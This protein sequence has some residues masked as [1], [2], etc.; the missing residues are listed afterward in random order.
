MS[1]E[2]A[3]GRARLD[4]R[5]DIY[6]L[7]AVL[8][9]MLAG[10]PPF[11]GPTAQA[12]LARGS[13]SAAPSVRQLRPA[14]PEAVDAGG[15]EGAGRR[16]RRT[17]SPS[18][19]E[20][21]RALR[22]ERAD[23]DRQRR[24]RAAGRALRRRHRAA[25]PGRRPLGRAAR[26]RLPARA[27]RAVRLAPAP[28]RRRAG[29][30]GGDASASPCCPFDNLGAADDEY[31]ADGITDEIRGKLAALPGLQVT[32][33][34]APP[35]TRRPTRTWRRSRASWAWTICWWARS[36]GRKATAGAAGCG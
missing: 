35:S 5:T 30:A 34:R 17:G 24:P 32:A 2:Q 22:A 15:A 14:V 27:R 23:A 26:P 19:G 20:L 11:T 10:E 9:E 21:A 25:P 8:Y 7:G 18:A 12:M 29:G 3:G 36:A 31:F 1:P 28:R 6:S 16:C 4:A 13:P 33:S